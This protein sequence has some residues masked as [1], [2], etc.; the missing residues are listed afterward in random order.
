MAWVETYKSNEEHGQVKCSHDNDHFGEGR[1]LI[2][3]L[4]SIF[5]GRWSL[6]QVSSDRLV[7]V[8]GGHIEYVVESRVRGGTLRKDKESAHD[9]DVDHLRQ[10]RRRGTHGG[11]YPPWNALDLH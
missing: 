1:I 4:R 11:L 6:L 8:V 2:L 7:V 3:I 9:V 5:D 10:H